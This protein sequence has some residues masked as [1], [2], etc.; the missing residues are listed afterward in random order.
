[1]VAEA[2]MCDACVRSTPPVTMTY[3]LLGDYQLTHNLVTGAPAS[4]LI[5]SNPTQPA[6]SR[7]VTA[8]VAHCLATWWSGRGV[9]TS[10]D[11]SASTDVGTCSQ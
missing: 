8:S 4:S 10:A 3:S 2:A 9:A 6:G 11:Q 1:M 5:N 7:D